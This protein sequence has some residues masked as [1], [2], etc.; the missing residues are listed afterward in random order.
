MSR[1][2]DAINRLPL[3]VGHAIGAAGAARSYVILDEAWTR[4]RGPA[5]RWAWVLALERAG[6]FSR[7]MFGG[8]GWPGD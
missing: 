1:E 3:H 8:E 4:A 5:G 6:D 2:I 7:A